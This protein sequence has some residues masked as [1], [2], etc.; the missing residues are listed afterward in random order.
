MNAC[1]RSGLPAAAGLG[2]KAQHCRQILDDLPPVAFF[3][4][5][6]ENYMGAG[7]PP[8][9]WLAA[10]RERYPLSI[11]GVGLSLGSLSPLDGEHL[12]ALAA[13]ER[14]Y[15]PEMM[16]EH[17]AWS[18]VDGTYLND[19]LP[20]AYTEAMLEHFAARLSRVQERLGRPILIENP[21]AYF[22]YA[23]SRIP[24]PEFLA[25]LVR[26]TGC[27]I[28]LDVNN[29]HVSACNLGF[30]ACASL[31]AVPA[32]AVGEIHLAGHHLRVFDDGG[33][34]R[35]DDHG[36]R[37]GEEVWRLYRRAIAH[38]G[39]RPTLIEWDTEVPALSV[40]LDEARRADAEVAAAL[41]GLGEREAVHALGA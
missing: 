9:R 17:L 40:L 28:L 27:G 39:A 30:D 19:L 21:S 32:A 25:E 29:R 31:A 20:I 5:H 4:I 24:E 12:E 13:L 10:I 16:S 15:R 33:E 36:S 6:A 35:I 23:A 1:R 18:S 7:G 37:V 22:A 38:C 2:L 8:H 11:H 14:R 26:R 41:A 3:E 34:I